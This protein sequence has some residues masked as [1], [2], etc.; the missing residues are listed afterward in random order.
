[1]TAAIVATG[2]TKDFEK[3]RRT[4]WQR[5]R[6]EPDRRESFRAVDGID[7]NVESGEVFGI[8]GPNGAGKTTTMR[9]LSTLLEPSAGSA[10]VLGYD[11]VSQ[12]R[13]IRRRLGAVLSGERSLYWK[14]TAR[15]NLEYFAALYHVPPREAASRID[16]I[17]EVVHLEDR[18]DD[19]VEK[20][21]TGMR[22]RLVLARALLPEPSLLLLD[23][24]TV[25]LDPQAA[26]DLRERVLQLRDEGRTV[27]L[28]TH[29]MEE[30]DQL[31]DRIA[32]VDHGRIVAL[33]TPDGLK[34]GL[35][36]TEV[37]RLE[38]TA[39]ES[40]DA[41]LVS[42]VQRA[43]E[44]TQRT[45]E[46]GSLHL[47][48]HCGSARDLVPLVIEAARDESAEVRNIQVLPISLEDVF[49]SL[50]GRALRE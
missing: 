44:V 39:P 49:I 18:A 29:Y 24:P 50:T 25:G 41:A 10:T 16:R 40:A 21:S 12:A 22:Q 38:V 43:G 35:K 13:D 9:M 47:T 14:L 19:Y 7:L 5:L 46:D 3:G 32:I 28:T 1:M 20:F 15:E 4:L 26:R 23:E 8:L 17:L 6:R 36:A 37:V 45:R 27:L 42:H 31:C 11:L 30:A 33:D 48:V 2:L 34:R